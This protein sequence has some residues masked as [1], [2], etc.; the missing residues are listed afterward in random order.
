[1]ILSSDRE[2]NRSGSW[3][4]A[5][6]AVLAAHAGAGLFIS[7]QS[8]PPTM[9]RESP[10]AVE[11]V[12]PSTAQGDP[13]SSSAA[14]VAANAPE[15]ELVADTPAPPAHS[16]AAVT[17][18][19]EPVPPIGASSPEAVISDPVPPPEL[20]VAEEIPPLPKS[21]T[22]APD[23]VPAPVEAK[24]QAPASPPAPTPRAAPKTPSPATP[25]RLRTSQ[26]TPGAAPSPS[27]SQPAPSP[28][29]T[30]RANS[31]SQSAAWQSRLLSHLHRFKRYPPSAQMR[32]RE[33]TAV[34]G[35]HLSP[36]GSVRAVHLRTSAGTDT[37]DEE[38]I[39]LI[40]RAQPLPVPDPGGVAI[41]IIVPIQFS[42]R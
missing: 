39:A 35:F 6:L 11:L 41:D 30:S 22:V 33:G 21:A 2:V 29:S 42:L 26:A 36:D 8:I 1:M 25:S 12:G 34:V 24:V 3:G 38:A 9:P 27:P 16:S 10:I 15:T 40:N 31:A 4:F 28:E 23:P 18:D 32:R 14:A 20:V 37:L 5:L 19:A 13:S 17:P 7:R